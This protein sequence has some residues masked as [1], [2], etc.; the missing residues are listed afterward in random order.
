MSTGRKL[1]DLLDPHAH[2]A[3]LRKSLAI[4]EAAVARGQGGM[5]ELV[6]VGNGIRD[7]GGWLARYG[8]HGATGVEDPQ[9]YSA[10]AGQQKVQ[11]Q[12]MDAL[13]AAEAQWTRDEG[14]PPFRVLVHDHHGTH[15]VVDG[16][17]W[18]IRAQCEGPLQ[19]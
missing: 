14:A 12:V 10:H 9:G 7:I 1:A 18:C 15:V 19:P 5:T 8:T 17:K 2:L 3:A 4:A 6:E 16:T 13:L 11:T